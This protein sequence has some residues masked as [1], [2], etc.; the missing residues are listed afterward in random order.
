MIRIVLGNIGSGKTLHMVREIVLNKIGRTY[1]T[2]IAIPKCKHVIP[3]KP[4][5]IIKVNEDAKTKKEKY[6]VNQEFWEN[7]VNE[8]QRISVCLDEAHILLNPRR[9]MSSINVVMTDWLALLR[10]VIGANSQTYGELCLITQLSRR[11]DPIS[12]EM[13]NNITWCFCSYTIYCNKCGFYKRETNETAKKMQYCHRCGD[14][15]LK[16]ANHIIQVFEFIS[17]DRYEAFIE[18]GHKTY[19]NRYVITDSEKYF[20][21]YN[22]LQWS[23]LLSKY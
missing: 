10:R 16:K 4:E 18:H 17:F 22:T 6:E 2:N 13:A 7:V 5:M 23:D 9:A 3:L 8:G 12:K 1:Y 14:Y 20:S 19:F 21:Y 15:N 11:L